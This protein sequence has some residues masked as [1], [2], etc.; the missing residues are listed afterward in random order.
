MIDLAI[1]GAGPSAISAAIY[2]A[3]DGLNVKVFEKQIIGGLVSQTDLI[4]NYPGFE[5][6]ITGLDLIKKMRLQAEKFGAKFE[7]AE[8]SSLE[9][10]DGYVTFLADGFEL[11]ARAILL[12]V[13]NEY[14]KLGIENEDRFIG[15]GI[16]F[17]GTCDGP[18]FKDKEVIA[19]GGGNSAVQEAIFISKYASKVHLIVRSDIKAQEVLKERLEDAV[20]KGKIVVY[21]GA[22]IKELLMDAENISGAK[23][24]FN[25]SREDIDILSPAI[26]E[27]I[28]LVPNTKWLDGSGV[29]TNDRGEIIVDK[30][31]KTSL[32]LVYATGDAIE[33]AKK[34]II[35]AA[36]NGALAALNIS[37]K[38]SF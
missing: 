20:N 3:R 9:Q 1:V 22:Q 16:Y 29:E 28:G 14:K 21:K 34:Q 12:A 8:V 32:D 38:L 19:V 37:K 13:G 30:N 7:Y 18:L 2:A 25:D 5:E 24:I 35:I 11:K 36:G 4:E 10:K 31:L 6:G 15:R 17:C 23:I 33:D 27:F 26:F